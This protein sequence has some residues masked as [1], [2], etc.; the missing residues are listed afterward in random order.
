MDNVPEPV[1]AF[2]GAAVE[3]GRGRLSLAD[4]EELVSLLG[5]WLSTTWFPLLSQMWAVLMP[6]RRAPLTDMPED[7][8]GSAPLK[9]WEE[10]Y[11]VTCASGI[12]QTKS[13]REAFAGF[14][15]SCSDSSAAANRSR[16]EA[17]NRIQLRIAFLQRQV[18][19][20]LNQPQEAGEITLSLMIRAV[21]RLSGTCMVRSGSRSLT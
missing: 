10:S 9:K 8:D 2:R 1:I 12:N 20:P 21:S 18:H 15:G 5:A 4:C 16:L 14:G 11:C 7:R 17:H 13:Y 3:L 6:R 19:K